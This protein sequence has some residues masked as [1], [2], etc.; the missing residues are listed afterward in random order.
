MMIAAAHLT[1][2]DRL[3]CGATIT[4]RE[5]RAG[6]QFRRQYIRFTSPGLAE[7][8][9]DDSCADDVRCIAPTTRVWSNGF[10]LDVVR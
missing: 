10:L 9:V 5:D 8:P 2:G 4:I 6:S 1:P 3:A 7:V